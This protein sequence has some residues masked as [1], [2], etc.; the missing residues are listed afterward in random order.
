MTTLFFAAT[1]R[2]S[3]QARV[4]EAEDVVAFDFSNMGFGIPNDVF[5]KYIFGDHPVTT[6]EY[7]RMKDAAAWVGQWGGLL[8]A[9]SDVGI[10]MHFT[11]H[12]VKFL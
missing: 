8:E 5:Q 4:T 12:L 6:E 11:V 7:Q 3:S 10:G 2:T 9:M 1:G